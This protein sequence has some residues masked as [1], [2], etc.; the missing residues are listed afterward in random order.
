VHPSLRG[1]R[2]YRI[3][4]EYCRWGGSAPAT[5]D[6]DIEWI[7]RMD[8]VMGRPFG[9]GIF[10]VNPLRIEGTT[11][12]QLLKLRG[13]KFPVMVGSM[14]QMGVSDP[15]RVL[16]AFV[17]GIA[18]VWGA[19]AIVREITGIDEIMTEC[20]IWPS[21]RR[22]LDIVYGAPEMVLGDLVLNQ[23][24]SFYGWSSPDSDAFHSSA[25]FPDQQA[26]AQR[27]AFGMAMALA[28]NRGFRFGGLLGIDLVFSPEQLVL[29]VE[30]LS[31]LRRV[32]AGFEFSEDAFCLE[33]IRRVGP[34]GCFLDDDET[35]S[36][37]GTEIWDPEIWTTG[38][39]GSW[40]AGR[41]RLAGN[42]ARERVDKLIAGQ[43]W[44]LDAARA[45]ALDDLVAAAEL[46]LVH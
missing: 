32:A 7:Y 45:S 30:T 18:A 10:V 13:G 17:I 46:A 6:E 14:P 38:T 19:Y 16:G 5:S 9:L 39:L 22:S 40:L 23:L 26:A 12:D 24:R 2:S 31:Y 20:R 21:S 37:F 8:E 34:S 25:L 27:G 29:D 33:A 15:A 11:F 42:A 36:R 43:T 35:L 4:A 41:T 28:G 3:G 1:I 44:R